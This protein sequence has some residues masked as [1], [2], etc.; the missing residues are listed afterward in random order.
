MKT[1]AVWCKRQ[2]AAAWLVMRV[3]N[4]F[5]R[6]AENPV[7]ALV[8]RAD[9]QAWEVECF[10][11]LH[12]PGF[13]AD[14][15]G[16]AVR[17]AVLPGASLSEALKAGCLAPGMLAAAGVELRRAHGLRCGYFGEAWSHGDP[18]SGNY[19]F[20]AATGRARLID[21]ELRHRRELSAVERHADD[22]LV[23][24]QD[25]CGRCTAEAWLPLALAFLQSYARPEVVAVLRGRL[26]VPGGWGRLWWGVRTSW[27][28]RAELE[29]RIGALALALETM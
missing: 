16:A 17:L 10:E 4:G 20:D 3:A 1:G 27:M 9:W 6:L 7:E 22:L 28:R 14:V 24:L 8:R 12:G 26:R 19:I 18:H 23:L 5:F 15:A 13:T 21:F 29:R 25:V 11:L 2:R